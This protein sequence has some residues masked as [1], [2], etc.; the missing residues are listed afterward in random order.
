MTD[1]PT[2][3]K[4]NPALTLTDIMHD[5]TQLEHFKVCKS[6]SSAIPNNQMCI[7]TIQTFL[8]KQFALQEHSLQMIHEKVWNY[9]FCTVISFSITLS[10]GYALF[11]ICLRLA[12]IQQSSV[13]CWMNKACQ[14]ER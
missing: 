7:F 13:K 11:G 4:S 12:I 2:N 10:K 3:L 1:N 6:K 5:D 9:S 8:R 14:K